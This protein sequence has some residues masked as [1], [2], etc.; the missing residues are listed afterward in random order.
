MNET[1]VFPNKTY[2]LTI[3]LSF[4]IWTID[5]LINLNYKRKIELKHHLYNYQNELL[6]NLGQFM[7]E[8]WLWNRLSDCAFGVS[9]I[10]FMILLGH[11][12][13]SHCFMTLRS[14]IFSASFK[15]RRSFEMCMMVVATNRPIKY[16]NFSLLVHVEGPSGS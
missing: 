13:V 2:N 3:F 15:W 9:R 4:S 8:R 5:Y 6:T 11:C 16:V 7:T 1:V 12:K 14:S 10:F